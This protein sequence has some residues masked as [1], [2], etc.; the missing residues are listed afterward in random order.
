MF[1][2]KV[3]E[4]SQFIVNDQGNSTILPQT[5]S[6]VEKIHITPPSTPIKASTS[7]EDHKMKEIVSKM[8]CSSRLAELKAS[9]NRY[10]QLETKLSKVGEKLKK[11]QPTS[12]SIKNF[13]TVEFTIVRWVNFNLLF[14][15][16]LSVFRVYIIFFLAFIQNFI[17]LKCTICNKPEMLTIHLRN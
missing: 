12:P 16:F 13:K 14:Y 1:N 5:Y 17:H 9:I 10:K 15:D 3:K 8:S 4:S 11:G 2:G 6:D 7:A